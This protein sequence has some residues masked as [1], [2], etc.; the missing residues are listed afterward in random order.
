MFLAFTLPARPPQLRSLRYLP[1]ALSPCTACFSRKRAATAT[2]LSVPF[3]PPDLFAFPSIAFTNSTAAADFRPELIGS[4]LWTA[5]LYLGFSQHV[6]WG[7]AV[8][9]FLT[10]RLVALRIPE[11]MSESIASATHSLPFLAAGFGV[12]AFLRYANGTNAIWA[13]ASGVSLAMYGG[14]YELGRWSAKGK[15]VSDD[16]SDVYSLFEEFAAR[17]L[18][19][20]GMCHLIDV[21]TAAR[22]DSKARRLNTLSD[23]RLRRFIR[24]RFPKARRSP[25]GY[26]RGMSVRQ[27]ADKKYVSPT[28]RSERSSR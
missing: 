15:K 2:L 16:E 18:V 13:L 12:D 9:S 3:P 24:N 8:L 17:R 25:N 19:P 11:E 7:S 14:I 26:Y 20:R 4:L 10:T 28:S 1:S 23:E 27:D 22:Q 21:R 5:G 6:R